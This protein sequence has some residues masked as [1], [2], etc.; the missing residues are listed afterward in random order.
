M[1][2]VFVVGGST[3]FGGFLPLALEDRRVL[4]PTG[5]VALLPTA[6]ECFGLIDGAWLLD[7]TLSRTISLAADGAELRVLC[8][9]SDVGLFRCCGRPR[10]PNNETGAIV[11]LREG[12]SAALLE[13]ALLLRVASFEG[14][15][16]L[17][18]PTF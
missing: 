16:E 9:A 17:N 12:E 15:G 11:G 4:P 6:D 18:E 14:R 10:C 1:V 5:A 2:D 8:G 3:L 13:L 7:F